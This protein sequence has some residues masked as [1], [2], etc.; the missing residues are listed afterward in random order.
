MACA[1]ELCDEDVLL[2]QEIASP[3]GSPTSTAR[4]AVRRLGS[5]TN[6][7]SPRRGDSYAVLGTGPVEGSSHSTDLGGSS[8]VDPYDSHGSWT[9][10]AIEWRLKLK[11][12][13][14]AEGFRIHNLFLSEEYDDYIGS[15]YNDKFYIF[16][17]AGS[18]N[19]G[20]RTVINFGDCRDPD[21]YY[22]FV[23]TPGMQFCNP[24]QRYCYIAINSGLSECC[25]YQG[26]PRGTATTDISGTGFECASSSGGDSESH[27]SSTGWFVTEW[28]IEPNEEFELVFHVH[29][30]GD[31]VF[32]S[33]VII[34][35]F[36][37]LTE[38][39][40]GTGG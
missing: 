20:E 39:S 30:T 27:G 29:D 4:A 2:E 12:P 8:M 1:I 6:D 38:V 26:C 40:P 22:D 31:G 25:W 33:Q 13:P 37:F 16:L 11:A 15:K 36:L 10:N 34:D 7:L 14:D 28:P 35:E 24:G 21:D 23:C 17:E 32:D 9:Y 19:S 5:A 3:T 18:T